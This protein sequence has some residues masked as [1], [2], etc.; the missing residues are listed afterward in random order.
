MTREN[1]NGAGRNNNNRSRLIAL[2]ALTVAAAALAVPMMRTGRPG[3]V[4]GSRHKTSDGGYDEIN[5]VDYYSEIHGKGEPL[6]VLHG[7]LGSIDMFGPVLP[8]LSRHHEVIAVDLHGHGRTA[9]GE[10]AI[11]VNEMAD[12][13]AVL[14]D[15][16]GIEQ[17]DAF[18][19]SLGGEVALRLAVQHPE[20]VRRLVLV[21]VP[22]ARDGF[23]PEIVAIQSQISASTADSMKDTPMF[24]A[25]SAVAPDPDEFPELLNRLGE[26]LRTPYDWHD[27]ISKLSMPVMLVYG[28]SDMIRPEHVL[29]F[30]QLLG[31]GR[32]DAG[33]MREHMSQ[34]RLAILPGLTHYDIFFSPLLARTALS[35]LNGEEETTNWSDLVAEQAHTSG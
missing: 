14:M 3:G 31:G 27:D 6:L 18:G 29:R 30:Y 5:D 2:G 8:K 24:R 13:M 25:Y 17:I 23:Y 9:L 22:F 34:N 19:Y 21:S 35:F 4:N 10:R 20:K 1:G 11:N 12:D 28:D 33:W 26:W 15:R 16:L 32:K 7:A